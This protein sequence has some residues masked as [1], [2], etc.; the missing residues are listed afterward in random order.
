MK[1]SKAQKHVL[2][3]MKHGWSL[4]VTS[5]FHTNHWL[6]EDG[7]GRGG[8][9]EKVNANTFWAIASKNWVK[10]NGGRYPTT[11]YG[12]TGAGLEIL[13]KQIREDKV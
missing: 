11:S 12:I 4:C 8:N 7:C 2:L 9:T 6:Q 1:L 5:G 10:R 13:A 3:L